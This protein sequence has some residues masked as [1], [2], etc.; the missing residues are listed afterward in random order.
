MNAHSEPKHLNVTP[1]LD[2]NLSGDG[3]HRES[4]DNYHSIVVVLNDRYRVI[5][6]RDQIQWILQKQNGQRHGQNRWDSV[7][8]YR[9][10]DGVIRSCHAHAGR[11]DANTLSILEN[12]PS[13]IGGDE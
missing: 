4:A 3:S 9:T 1:A 11:L 2:F 8:F 6:C 12:L 7:K 5:V 10:R 13:I